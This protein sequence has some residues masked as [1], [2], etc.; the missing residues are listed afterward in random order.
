MPALFQKILC[1]IDFDDNS[2][3]ALD[4]AAQLA[5][6]TGG[7]IEVLHVIPMVMQPEGSGYIDVYTAEEEV[8]RNK[9]QELAAKHLTGVK[10]ELRTAVAQP[11]AAILHSAKTLGADL[12]VMGTHGRRGLSHMILGSVA[13]RVVREAECPA[14]TIRE[15]RGAPQPTAH[16]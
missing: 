10:F 14:L 9:L 16:S 1:P 6:E 7:T 4:T 11:A 3:V 15:H 5:R 8:S 12:I 2:I 13:E